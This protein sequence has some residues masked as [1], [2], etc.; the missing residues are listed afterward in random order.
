LLW[1]RKDDL[2]IAP[3]QVDLVEVYSTMNGPLT[4]RTESDEVPS[5]RTS[6]SIFSYVAVRSFRSAATDAINLTGSQGL[7]ARLLRLEEHAQSAAVKEIRSSFIDDWKA[8]SD[9]SPHGVC[10]NAEKSFDLGD[11]IAAMDFDTAAVVPPRHASPGLFDKGADVL[12]APSSYS[13]AKLNWF[14]K[15]A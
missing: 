8:G 5:R 4:C 2:K 3:R 15:A 12:D 11:R 10:V 1:F 13:T 9:P 14:R 7:L 6:R